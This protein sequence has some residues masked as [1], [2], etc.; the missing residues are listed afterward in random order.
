M[1]NMLS[2]ISEKKLLL[3]AIIFSLL[4]LFS[5]VILDFYT[6]TPYIL[7]IASFLIIIIIFSNHLYG[8]NILINP[9]SIFSF[10]YI[11][12]A[13]GAYYYAFSGGDFGKFISYL[14]LDRSE[15]E[16][17]LN[18]AL[19]Y[20]LICYVFFVFGFSIFY[21]K[22]NKINLGVS[23]DNLYILNYYKPICF[24]LIS[25]G[26]SYW[27]WMSYTLAGGV[28]QMLFYFQAFRHLIE[29]A[30][31][32]TLPYHLY[33]S[34]VFFW[35][36]AS[37]TKY[38]KVSLYFIFFSFL[39]L[40]IG[41]STGRITLAF[42]YI[43]AQLI[44]YYYCFPEKRKK[45]IF[46]LALLMSFGFVIY[47]LRILSNQYFM[48]VDLDLSDKSFLGTIIGDGNITDLQQLVIVFKTFDSSNILLGSSYFD[49]FR[50]TIGTQFGLQPHSIGLLIK[51]L[52][53]PNTSGA[54]TPGAIGEAYA[55]FL[56]CG[57]IIMF[58]VGSIFSYIYMKVSYSRH[59]LVIMIYAIFLAR[60]VFMYP[61]VDSTMMVNFLW[62]AMPLLLIWLF[63]QSSLILMKESS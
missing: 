20:A 12:Y 38:N 48:G 6:T 7:T 16:K 58:M 47:F 41:L 30:Q 39:G 15:V 52:Y 42:T 5:S 26:L 33:Y 17:L 14:N 36:I 53:I 55:N 34:G 51:E 61:K 8:R 24:I 19:F 31:L 28:V 3:S 4:I 40:V 46:I 50:N 11:G 1:R 54:P 13:F 35:L 2:N 45:I 57:P 18:Y 9:L 49:T 21:K 43:M 22:V 10:M 27:V 29:D 62:G 37:T 44:F 25:I 23:K 59:P 56:F 32:T 63:V 60:F